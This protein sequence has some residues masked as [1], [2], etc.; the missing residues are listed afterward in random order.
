MRK[1]RSR[2][3]GIAHPQV[4]EPVILPIA[5]AVAD[6][7]NRP[8]SAYVEPRKPL[9]V[10]EAAFNAKVPVSIGMKAANYTAFGFSWAS[11]K[12]AE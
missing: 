11:Y 12:P 9:S 2:V 6:A 4:R 3:S 1:Y 10:V 7:S 8:R 5:V